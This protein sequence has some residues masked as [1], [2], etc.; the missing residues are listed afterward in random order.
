[1]AK[2]GL[3]WRRAIRPVVIADNNVSSAAGFEAGATTMKQGRN[4]L[5]GGEMPRQRSEAT[6]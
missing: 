3:N 1:M 4:S 5:V 6:A 2:G